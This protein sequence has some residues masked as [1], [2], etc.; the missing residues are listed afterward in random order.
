[1]DKN[2]VKVQD[3]GYGSALHIPE[4]ENPLMAQIQVKQK[5]VEATITGKISD[6]L[7]MEFQ[8][9]DTMDGHIVTKY[10]LEPL[11][12][13]EPEKYLWQEDG[14]VRRNKDGK[15]IYRYSIYT[16]DINDKDDPIPE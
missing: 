6:M 8:P 11:V 7:Y 9:G 5:E 3:N 14:K 16:E 1:M 12:L 10:S 15:A 2:K 4:G 13:D